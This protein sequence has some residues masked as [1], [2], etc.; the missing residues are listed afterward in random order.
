MIVGFLFVR[1]IHF[2]R[3]EGMKVARDSTELI[4]RTPIVRLNKAELVAGG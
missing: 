1:E 3:E 4:G 2:G